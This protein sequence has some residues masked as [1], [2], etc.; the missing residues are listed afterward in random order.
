MLHRAGMLVTALSVVGGL[1]ACGG[2]S[3]ASSAALDT[4]VAATATATDA[5]AAAGPVAISP[6]PGTP[7]ASPST[8]ISF[9]GGPGTTISAVQVVGSSSG[10]HSGSLRAYSTGTGESF[11]P[12]RSTRRRAPRR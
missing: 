5:T 4:S 8:Q 9:L 6:Q 3:T 7:D 2:A 1:A 11:L 10:A 12:S